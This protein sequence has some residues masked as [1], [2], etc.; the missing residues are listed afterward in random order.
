MAENLNDSPATYEENQAYLRDPL[1]PKSK[2]YSSK[3]VAANEAHRLV[4]HL[5]HKN[6]EAGR[7]FY[8]EEVEQAK[9]DGWVDVPFV[10]PNNPEHK[11]PEITSE[12]TLLFEEAE[13][14]G[15]KVDKRLSDTKLRA[16]IVE[17]GK[18]SS[19]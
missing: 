9:A 2:P 16:A 5:Y 14:L 11:E 8:I 4:T 18:V 15:V 1:D 19:G 7:D 10:H 3:Q 12:R 13:R 6:H 17:A